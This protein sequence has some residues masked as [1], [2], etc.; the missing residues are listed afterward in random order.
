VIDFKFDPEEIVE[1]NG[2]G[3]LTLRTGVRRAMALPSQQRQLVVLYRGAGKEPAFFSLVHIE[4]LAA[5]PEFGDDSGGRWAYLL[6][7]SQT[8]R[9]I[10]TSN[11]V[12]RI[13]FLTLITTALL[14]LAA[15]PRAGDALAQPQRLTI[16]VEQANARYTQQHTIDVGDVPGH[17]VRVFEV[18]RTYPSNPPVVNGMKIVESW[19]RGISDYTN[20]SGPS[21]VYHVY[22]GENGDKFFITSS[23]IAVQAPGTRKTTITTVG[24]ITGGTGEFYGI[25]GV[26]R[27]SASS[28]LEAGVNE[29]QVELEYFFSR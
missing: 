28:D 1:C 19:T 26:M 20:N 3:Y 5:L 2:V 29:S 10:R 21:V 12:K 24:T 27:L 18:R 8:A 9:H 16:K 7:V 23:A 17:Q 25:Q 6:C 22:V 14:C 4:Q 15:A 11:A 13:T